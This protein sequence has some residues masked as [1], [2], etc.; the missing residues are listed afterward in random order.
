MIVTLCKPGGFIKREGR[1]TEK[2]VLAS[3]LIDRPMRPLFPDDY[4]NDVA[5][6]ATVLS[7]DQDCSSE[8]T[9]MLGASIAVSISDI[10]WNGPTAAVNIGLVDGKFIV[11]PTSAEREASKLALSRSS[12][13]RYG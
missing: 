9:A 11:N 10:P 7:V 4:R 5:V 2:A 6:V 3:R 8:I 13:G 1:P 12:F